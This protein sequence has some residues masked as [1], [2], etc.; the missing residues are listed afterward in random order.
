ML[1]PLLF[2]VAVLPTQ[3][4]MVASLMKEHLEI[5]EC[6]HF[7]KRNVPSLLEK[8]M[9]KNVQP[10]TTHTQKV[11]ACMCVLT[12]HFIRYTL[13][14]PGWTRFCLQNCLETV[15][16]RQ[17]GSECSLRQILTLPSE[18]HHK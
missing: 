8:K 18:C 14:V 16:T 17:D 3:P 5:E 6:I 10:I 13:L 11:R 7:Q 15:E 2:T 9:C 1:L 12:G 4:A